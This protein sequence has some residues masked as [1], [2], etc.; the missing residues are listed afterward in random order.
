[1]YGKI[2][3]KILNLELHLNLPEDEAD[4]LAGLMLSRLEKIPHPQEKLS[5]EQVEF[6]VERATAKRIISVILNIKE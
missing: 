3:I 2:P 1:M 6:T 5:F 4:T